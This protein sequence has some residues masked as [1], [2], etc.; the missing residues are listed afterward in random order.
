MVP[1]RGLVAE[2]LYVV[3]FHVCFKSSMDAS[4]FEECFTEENWYEFAS[5]HMSGGCGNFHT[6]T[7]P[8]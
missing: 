6:N 4:S 1:L 5:G 3:L 8:G 7:A 2:I